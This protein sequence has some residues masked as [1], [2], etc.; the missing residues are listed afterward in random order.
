MLVVGYPTST[1]A[2]LSPYSQH[3]VYFSATK[4][5]NSPLGIALPNIKIYKYSENS[6]PNTKFPSLRLILT[7]L[8][9]FDYHIRSILPLQRFT[10]VSESGKFTYYMSEREIL[11]EIKRIGAQ[12]TY[13]PPPPADRR[14]GKPQRGLQVTCTNEE[15]K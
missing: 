5:L 2:L 10:L 13:K 6:V 12:A 1:L 15:L 9:H 14:G 4:F 8:I 3:K 11:E 7:I